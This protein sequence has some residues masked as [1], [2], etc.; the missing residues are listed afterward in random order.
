VTSLGRGLTARE[1]TE[2]DEPFLRLLYDS[3]RVEE[4]SGVSWGDRARRAFLDQ[5]FDAQAHDYRRRFPGARYLVVERDAA[6]IGRLYLADEGDAVRVLDI[7]LLPEHR[8]AGLG[9][10]ILQW[11]IDGGRPVS[12][13]VGKWN[14]AQ[15]LYRRLA[16]TVVGD[17]GAY[18]AMARSPA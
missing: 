11:V 13:A 5:Q 18:L 1:A 16:F 2:A 9:E 4:L 7:A 17:E 8:N 10:A 6:P 14:P 12:L 15:R 3:T